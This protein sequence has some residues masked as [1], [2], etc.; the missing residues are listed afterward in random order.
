M[1]GETSQIKRE[2]DGQEFVGIFPINLNSKS[3]VQKFEN[4]QLI[5]ER[6][7]PQHPCWAPLLLHWM[8]YSDLPGPWEALQY[9]G[10]RR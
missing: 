3:S 4:V 8:G 2:I 6:N 5:K 10:Q 7:V 9:L 1:A